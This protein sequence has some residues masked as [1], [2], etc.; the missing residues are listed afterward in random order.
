MKRFLDRIKVSLQVN[1]LFLEL[2]LL[3]LAGILVA[4][5]LTLVTALRSSQK[6]YLN[7]VSRSVKQSLEQVREKMDTQNQTNAAIVNT[8][9]TDEASRAYLMG[10]KDS[11]ILEYRTMYY[12]VNMLQSLELSDESRNLKLVMVN[13]G[14]TIFYTGGYSGIALS[15]DRILKA[16]YTKQAKNEVKKIH[17]QFVADGLSGR[18]EDK[19][20]V[21]VSAAITYTLGEA[22][23]GYIYFII[24]QERLRKFYTALSNDA[25]RLMLIDDRGVVI[26]AEN[27]KLIG[28]KYPDI[29][30]A[31]YKVEN[32]H[33]PFANAAFNGAKV[34]IVAEP[35]GKWGMHAVGIIDGKIAAAMVREDSGYMIWS[36]F[37]SAL[38][39]AVILFWAIRKRTKPLMKLVEHMGRVREENTCEKIHIR[40]GYEVQQLENAYNVMV[41]NINTYIEN[42][43]TVEKNKREI[44][45]SK[46][47][48]Q[49][50]PHFIYNTLASIKFL[51]WNGE[52]DKAAQA[53]DMF[54]SLLQS[55][56]SDDEEMVTVKEEFNNLKRY[57]VL[58]KIRFG[59]SIKVD[60]NMDKDAKDCLIPKLV[61]QPF[62][63]N[64][65]FHA[66][67][68]KYK[69][70]MICVYAKVKGECLLCEILDNGCGITEEQ[71]EIHRD[72]STGI[73]IANVNERLRLMFG[74]AYSIEVSSEYGEGTIVTVKIPVHRERKEDRD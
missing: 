56:I 68:Q 54:T 23:A 5:T 53:V 46:L 4:S 61:L 49:I 8:L 28:K 50:N 25:C 58:Q 13:R 15:P 26:S 60:I 41:E 69:N 59:D 14:G 10:Q 70:A 48:M 35:F 31:V 65:F 37:V 1:G 17:Y 52:A 38:L 71:A 18:K 22:P 72:T 67:P 24:S 16:D 6:I 47:R 12:F 63:E 19:N 27:E 7:T 30:K 51:I 21:V 34:S 33:I 32:D 64:A 20:C 43:M 3:A 11:P 45:L 39:L 57:I 62:I 2:V 40:G 36:S 29:M 55:T 66:F 44:E 74:E 73:G 9:R 42:I